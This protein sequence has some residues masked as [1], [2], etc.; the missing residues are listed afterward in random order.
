MP[1]VVASANR[2]TWVVAHGLA[3][4]SRG[5]GV[6]GRSGRPEDFTR[7]G[8]RRDETGAIFGDFASVPCPEARHTQALQG[9]MMHPPIRHTHGAQHGIERS[10]RGDSQVQRTVR[11]RGRGRGGCAEQGMVLLPPHEGRGVGRATIG[12]PA[13]PRVGPR[14]PTARR[15]TPAKRS[16]LPRSERNPLC[17]GR[18]GGPQGVW[19]CEPDP[20]GAIA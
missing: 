12:G 9:R 14:R 8:R 2:V 1:N 5:R 16:L 3:L 20:R 11:G 15:P 10:A 19:E 4:L 13:R 6:A 18:E 7:S 17:I